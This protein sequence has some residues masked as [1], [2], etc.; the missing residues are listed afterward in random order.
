[1]IVSTG[2]DRLKNRYVISALS[3]TENG[4][5]GYI[6]LSASFTVV[7]EPIRRR[8]PRLK[9]MGLYFTYE[10]RVKVI[11]AFYHKAKILL[12]S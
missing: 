1:M 4:L 2:I 8:Q 12:K 7:K 11:Y 10:S 3:F 5:H 9:R 6:N